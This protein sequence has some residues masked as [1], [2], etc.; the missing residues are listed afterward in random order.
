M[1]FAAAALAMG[2]AA[3]AQTVWNNGGWNPQPAAAEYPACSG[4][5]SDDR[6]I[7]LYERGVGTEANL[8]LNQPMAGDTMLA[9]GEAGMIMPADGSYTGQGGPYEP[10]DPADLAAMGSIADH[11]ARSNYPPCP[12][13]DAADSCIQLYERGV[14]GEVN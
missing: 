2:G 12:R 3:S 6:C 10:V 13:S 8:A 9:D 4:A 14:T 7:Q 11:A 1:M 5:E